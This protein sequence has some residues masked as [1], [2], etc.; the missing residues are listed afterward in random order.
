VIKPKREKNRA[1]KSKMPCAK[2]GSSDAVTLYDDGSSFCFSCKNYKRDHHDDNESG[3]KNLTDDFE[4]IERTPVNS[5]RVSASDVKDFPII[6][7]SNRGLTKEV[8]EFYGVH[9]EID[10]NRQVLKHFYPYGED[11]YKV[12]TVATKDFIWINKS[13]TLFGQNKFPGGGKRV[14]VTEGEIDA[15]SVAI[16]SLKQYGQVY[17]AVSVPSATG[18]SS[19]LAQREWLRTFD[20]V[21]LAFD[22]DEAGQ[23]AIAEAARIVGFDKVKIAKLRKKDPNEILLSGADG[24]K[25]LMQ[26]IWN[27]QRYIPGGIIG[28]AALWDRLERYNA[29]ESHPYPPCIG[30]LNEKVK[31]MRFGEI[32]LF[33]SGTGSGKSTLLREVMLHLLQTTTESIGVISLEESPEETA[34]KLAG[35]AL[36][37]NPA[38]EEIPL[39]ELREGFEA[40]FKGDRVILLDHQGSMN[41]GSLMDQLE[42]MCLMGCKYL[43]IDHITILV[44]EG[45]GNLTGNE[46]QDKV[47]NDLLRLCKRYDVWIGL[48]SHL[49]KAP[50][51]GKSFE[52][53]NIPSL[54]DIRGSGSV[55][56]VSFDVIAF[57]RELGADDPKERNTIKMKVLKS[58]FTGLTGSCTSAFYDYETGRLRPADS[59][60]DS[61]DV[62]FEAV[63]S[64]LPLKADADGVI[65]TSGNPTVG[66]PKVPSLSK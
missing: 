54:D 17:P 19:L 21:V 18:L 59:M 16:M 64:L 10:A 41:D 20:E 39:E 66:M 8:C 38:K 40:V 57:A 60:E 37:R 14:I 46:A 33:I 3:E 26:D 44:S 23:G 15:M 63:P 47:M 61:D 35:M 45:L 55:K 2:C 36:M 56:Q 30:S 27:A 34:R 62:D 28:K 50:T 12:R 29:I 4:T 7:I 42:Y 24:W 58:R 43:F 32:A 65:F 1:I 48:V 6:G 51:G 11:S 52:D 25:E 9:V 22:M 5:Q 49:R 53:G 31:G 13:D